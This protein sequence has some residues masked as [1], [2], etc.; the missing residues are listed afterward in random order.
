MERRLTQKEKLKEL[1]ETVR[2]QNR[3]V[4]DEIRRQKEENQKSIEK[5]RRK[6]KEDKRTSRDY[7]FESEQR[8]LAY[9]REFLKNKELTA[10]LRKAE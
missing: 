10:K 1:R 6:E 9:M 2:D 3:W 7:Q 4:H 8:R 5:A